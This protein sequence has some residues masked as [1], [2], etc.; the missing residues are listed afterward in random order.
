LQVRDR[1]HKSVRRKKFINYKRYQALLVKK[2]MTS[3]VALLA[4]AFAAHAQGTVQFANNLNG[5]GTYSYASLVLESHVTELGGSSK[6]TT[7]NPLLDAGNGNDWTVSLNGVAGANDQASSLAQLD[8]AGG[9]PVTATLETGGIDSTPGTWLSSFV[10][11]VPGAP[12]GSA[13]T[14]QIYAWYNDGGNL[15]DFVRGAGWWR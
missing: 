7:G 6:V 8:T 11:V 14:V 2:S 4:G 5:S 13:A 3:G 9:L 1:R 12:A 10:G 15:H